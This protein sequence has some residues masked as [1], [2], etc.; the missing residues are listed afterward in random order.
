MNANTV[1]TAQGD[2]P[3]HELLAD[4]LVDILSTMESMFEEGVSEYALISMLKKPPYAVF[5]E[6]ALR[7]PLV[8]FKTHFILF[9]ALYQLRSIWLKNGVGKLDIHTLN[10]RLD[11]DAGVAAPKQELAPE[12]TLASE[13]E[14][15]T[16]INAHKVGPHDALASY[17]LDWNNF[18]QTDEESVEA[19]LASFWTTMGKAQYASFNDGDIE[20]AHRILGL[21]WPCAALPRKEHDAYSL[22]EIKKHYRK[23]LQQLHP[24]KG[25]SREQAQ[26]VISAYQLLVRF[27]SFK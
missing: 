27:Y 3:L 7:D 23:K 8:L 2:S 22:K 21:T 15:A 24:D 14:S 9:N 20:A 16:T 19:L 18:E 11:S 5:D 4:M 25:G 6:E 10:I 26:Q 12:P 17:Y 13:D 1:S